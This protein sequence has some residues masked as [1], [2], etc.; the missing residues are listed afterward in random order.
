MSQHA[1]RSFSLPRHASVFTSELVAIHKALCLIE[2]SDEVL[3]TIFTDSLS[4]LLALRDINT[5]HPIL[6]GILILLT[7]LERA[8]KSV[9]FC[10][11]PSHVGIG[12]NER[13]DGAAKRATQNRRIRSVPV[14][15]RD[16]FAAFASHIRE[17]WQRDW[18]S[19]VASKLKD[20]KPRL[21]HWSSSFRRSRREE[22]TLCRLRIGHTFS[23]HRYLLCGEPKPCCPRCGNVLSVSHVLVGCRDLSQLRARFFGSSILTLKELLSD[24]SAY[25]M[26]VLRFITYVKFAIIYT[27]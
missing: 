25:I 7:S 6:Q 17:R 10:W 19:S 2:V 8:G 4:S 5:Y 26:Q 23:T 15:A 20:I 27:P 1:T 14:P 22:V 16:F 9:V 24:E 21:G 12:G 3:Y 13:A 11:I 18:E